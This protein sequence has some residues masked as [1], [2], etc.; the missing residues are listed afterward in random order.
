MRIVN[1]I[2][3]VVFLL[4]QYRLWFGHNGLQ[5]YSANRTEVTKLKSGNDELLKR[6]ELLDADVKDLKVGLEGIE[7]RARNELG[8]IRENETFFRL[9]PSTKEKK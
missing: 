4:I 2:L 9:I 6:N 7:E 8:M 5:F 3:I 1:F